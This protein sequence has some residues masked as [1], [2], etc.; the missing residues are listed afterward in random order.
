MDSEKL[1]NHYSVLLPHVNIYRIIP[2][3]KN[4]VDEF[5]KIKLRSLLERIKEL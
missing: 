4:L 3:P 5:I 1:Y 2:L